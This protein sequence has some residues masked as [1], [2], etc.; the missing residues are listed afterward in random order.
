MNPRCSA[1]DVLR[2][3]LCE[4]PGPPLY[5]DICYVHLC[6]TCGGQHILDETEHKVVPFKMRGSSTVCPK[7]SSKICELNCEQCDIPICVQ[8]ASSKEH[9]GH[10]F[11]DMAKTLK[12]RKKVLERDLHELE[13][14]IYPRYQKTA[15]TLLVQKADLN[16]NCKKLTTAIDEHGADLHREIDS[17][18]QE[19]KSYLDEMKSK[20]LAVLNKQ[21]DEI[22]HTMSEI[23]QGP[24]SRLQ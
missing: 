24:V 17:I 4:T 18:I 8:C 9:Q 6:T 7:H 13:N 10:E 21:E 3:H 19:M 22:K 14:Y 5:C 16:E 12:R 2:C 15:V 20:H 23:T 1:Q 11:V